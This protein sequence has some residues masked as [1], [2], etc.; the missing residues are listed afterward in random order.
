MT[1]LFNLGRW[2]SSGD[3][4]SDCAKSLKDLEKLKMSLPQEQ[5]E[6]S[7]FINIKA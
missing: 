5:Q 6:K 2:M 4:I 3:V 7:I 1:K